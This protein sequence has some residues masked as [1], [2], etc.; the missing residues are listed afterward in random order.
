M[1]K[2]KIHKKMKKEIDVIEGED[3]EKIIYTHSIQNRL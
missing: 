2:L 3:E 1:K